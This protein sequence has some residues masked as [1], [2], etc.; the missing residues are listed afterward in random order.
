METTEIVLL[1]IGAT[2][3][4]LLII[5]ALR[6]QRAALERTRGAAE[7]GS[8]AP[9]AATAERG[10]MVVLDVQHADPRSPAVERMV[11][12]AAARVYRMMPSAE[13]V[14]VRSP[15]GLTLGVVER[16]PAPE[17][18][19]EVPETLTEPRLPRSVG[20]DL[21]RHL[22]EP[23]EAE[24][25]PSP[26]ARPVFTPAAPPAPRRPLSERFDLPEAVS[27]RLRVTDDARDLVRAILEASGATVR[28]EGDVIHADGHAI[29]VL[30]P[31]GHVVEP[32]SLDHAYLCIERAGAGRGI[33]IGMG[34]LD[35]ADIRR[36]EALAPHVLH[37]GPDGIQRMADAV[38]IGEDPLRF[39][40]GPA[41]VAAPAPPAEPGPSRS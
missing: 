10:A 15:S 12:E 20:P 18:R 28:V 13:R 34:I 40:A 6:A 33:V 3:I 4:L 24:P 36:R 2:L 19:L 21:T 8:P 30:V 31:S 1:A 32:G 25:P 23:E 14:E 26:P 37:T 16:R 9:F 38:A 22:G 27:E 39:A 41:L 35:V 29:V 17:R 5:G 7:R 11:R